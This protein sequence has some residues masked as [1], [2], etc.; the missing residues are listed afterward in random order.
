MAKQLSF[1]LP[2]TPSLDRADF[3]PS[4]AN[5][6]AL[7]AIDRWPDWPQGKLALCGPEGAGKTHLAHI[8]AA[9]SGG[10]L[11]AA[12]ALKD[13]DIA[14]LAT[15]PLAIEDVPDIA[16][17]IAA[18][19]ALFHLHNLA[20]ANG[21]SLLFT[22]TGTPGDWGLTLPDLASRMQGTE[23]AIMQAPDDALLTAVLA[24][25]FADRQLTPRPDVI[26]YLVPHMPR[27]FDAARQLVE[28]LDREALS[29][30]RAITRRIAATVLDNTDA[31]E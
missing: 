30:G 27:S 19:E 16:G 18:Q 11:A 6:V 12:S 7:A 26:A 21:V 3:F 20:R 14:S 23:A 4:P 8:W 10:G 25:L 5:S 22:G 28:D 15:G 9:R 1:D 29:Q 2:A 17:D 31:A 24:K 13:A